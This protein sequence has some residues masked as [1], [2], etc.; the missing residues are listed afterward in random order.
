QRTVALVTSTGRITWMCL[1]RADSGAVFSELLGGPDGGYFAVYPAQTS[2]TPTQAYDDATFILRTSWPE[3]TVTD[4]LDCSA[5]RPF[6]RAGRT[7]L[8]RVLEGRGR[9]IIEFAARGDFGRAGTRKT[10]DGRGVIVEGFPDPLVLVAPG[11][12]W[13]IDD[14]GTHHT[15]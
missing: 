3:L 4:Y 14:D 11:I 8:V 5:G 7:D 6:Q 2:S 13:H 12:D 1:P 10:A 15:A 9:A